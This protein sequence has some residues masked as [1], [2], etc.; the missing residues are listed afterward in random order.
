MSIKDRL[1][2]KTEGL[3]LPSKKEG[4][5]PSTSAPLRT[6]PGQ[7]LM[8]N[9]LMKESNG[10][11]AA[12]EDRVRDFEGAIPVRLLDAARIIGSKW[13]NRDAA[14]FDSSDFSALKDEIGQAGGNVQPIK[15]RPV[16]SDQG[17]YEIVF[18]HRRHRACLD[19]NLPVLALVEE[20]SDKELFMEM[21]RENRVRADLSP[22]EQGM[23]YRR[24]LADGLFGSR[25]QLARDLGIDPGNLSKALRLAELDEA[26]VKAFSTPLDLQYRF[27]KPLHD[28]MQHD[29][30][31][32]LQRA[33]QISK[34]KGPPRTAK[35][36]LSILLGNAGRSIA[37]TPANGGM[38]SVT[39]VAD[40]V[41]LS[42]KKGSLSTSDIEK[43]QRLVSNFL[44]EK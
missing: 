8:V 10:R 25:E 3:F 14:G 12:L 2:K 15:V 11:V 29:R 30:E 34:Q 36:V 22:W 43:L 21:D 38:V 24:A 27:A 31:G 33:R 13:A 32:V 17:D 41:S 23:M 40:T 5:S 19:L 16:K 28:G 4:S 37:A 1:N 9:S 6:G 44:Q 26:V 39:T 18:G 20:V 42:F 7:M 35:E